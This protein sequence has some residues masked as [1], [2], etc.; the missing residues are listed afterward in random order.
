[1]GK[2]FEIFVE[3]SG[4]VCLF[5]LPVCDSRR[6]PLC[7]VEG[8]E[9]DKLENST[10]ELSNRA[11]ARDL[12]TQHLLCLSMLNWRTG[13]FRIRWDLPLRG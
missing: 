10:V 2:K 12:L 8:T 13:F 4:R 6:Q 5:V 9:T 11:A 7:E 1:M 3:L